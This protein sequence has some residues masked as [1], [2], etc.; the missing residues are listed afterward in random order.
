MTDDSKVRMVAAL[1]AALV[2]AYACGG[3]Q[4]PPAETPPSSEAPAEPGSTESGDPGAEGEH[5]MP[6]GSTMPG[7][8]HEGDE[9]EHGH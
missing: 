1:I 2:S 7:H 9:S 6:D 4:Q 5:T 3:Q 8:Q